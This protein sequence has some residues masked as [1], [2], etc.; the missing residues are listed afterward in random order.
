MKKGPCRFQGQAYVLV[1]YVVIKM[2]LK[3]MAA[4]SDGNCVTDNSIQMVDADLAEHF[5]ADRED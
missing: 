3:S 1:C 2:K 5:V 4:D